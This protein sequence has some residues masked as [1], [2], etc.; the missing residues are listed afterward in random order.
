MSSEGGGLWQIIQFN[1][2]AVE[3]EAR[4]GTPHTHDQPFVLLHDVQDIFPGAARFQCGKRAVGFMVDVDGNKLQPLRVPYLPGTPLEVIVS[5][6]QTTTPPL[7]PSPSPLARERASRI[8]SQKLRPRLLRSQPSGQKQELAETPV[9]EQRQQGSKEELRDEDGLPELSLDQQL[10]LQLQQPK[11]DLME[12]RELRRQQRQQRQQGTEQQAQLDEQMLRQKL[13][14]LEQQ[15]IQQEQERLRQQKLRRQEQLRQKQQQQQEQMHQAQP[16]QQE[17]A[18]E[19]QEQEQQEQEQQEQ[20]QQEQEHQEEEQQE[21]QQGQKQEQQEQ[22]QEQ[23]QREQQ[24]EQRQQRLSRQ[25]RQQQQQQQG[26]SERAAT[27]P[28]IPAPTPRKPRLP[29]IP[30]DDPNSNVRIST[31]SAKNK[32]RKSV[33]LY[34]SFLHHIRAGQTEQANVVK[35]DFRHHFNNLEL[36]MAKNQD[37]QERMLEMQQTMLE[38]QQRSL[39][40]LAVIQNRVQAILVQ[41][42]ELHEYP[43]PR[44]FVVLPK[45]S[46]RWDS[47]NLFQNKF[48]LYF[49]CECG[50]HTKSSQSKIP[51]HIHLAKHEGYDIER[52]REFFRRYG[53]YVLKLLQMLKYGVAVG[54]FA[55][56]ALVPSRV[57]ESVRRNNTYSVDGYSFDIEP[58]VNQAIEFLQ[59]L[60]TDGEVTPNGIRHPDDMMESL[61]GSDLRRLGAFLK[62]K[63]EDHVLGNLYRV[64]TNQGHV[65][66][67]CLDHYRETYNTLAMRELEDIATVNGGLVDEHYG[68]VVI[69]LYSSA[70]ATQFYRALERAKFVQELK[71]KLR[72]DITYSDAKAF[73]E[74][75]NRSNISALELTCTASN[76]AGELLNRNKRAE[77]LW[78]ILSNPKIRSFSLDG[79][80]GFFRRASLEV[81]PSE[82]RVLRIS[83]EIDWKKDY[84]KVVE[85]LQMS[86]H[87][88]DLTLG[89]TNMNEAYKAIR[90]AASKRCPLS[91]LT[92]KAG[93][94]ERLTA[95][96]EQDQAL[97]S[98]D[99]VIPNLTAYS[100]LLKAADCIS[101]LHISSQ[102]NSY[103]DCAP[104]VD[105]INRNRNLTELKIACYVSEFGLVYE[106]IR[107]SVV[108]NRSSRLKKVCIYRAENQLT[109]TDIRTPHLLSLELLQMN[110]HDG[111]LAQLL[112]T[113]GSKL[114]KL[115]I[116]TD[117]WRPIHSAILREAFMSSTTG[118]RLTHLYQTIAGVDEGILRELSMVIN[119]SNLAEYHMVIDQ[120]F[121]IDPER[122]MYWV[123]YI[124]CIG[125]KL[126]SLV[127]ACP[128]PNE[129]VAALG[130]ADFPAMERISFHHP[131]QR[132]QRGGLEYMTQEHHQQQQ[133]SKSE[134]DAN[135]MRRT[136]SAPEIHGYPTR[137]SA[138]TAN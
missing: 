61:E 18:Q 21:H 35:E 7:R 54:G 115:R 70:V 4:V 127:V 58:S 57:G 69:A 126:S 84:A 78:Q 15:Q 132:I 40:R 45:D 2:Q 80:S 9:Q 92:L 13:V 29:S 100:H 130:N 85:M 105:V 120:A 25:Q 66:W 67:V 49:L 124:T 123:D 119:R 98:M 99:L 55:V 22:Q 114:T 72:W 93:P 53:H 37:L 20:E 90:E 122:A 136:V 103:G 64:V 52:P 106:A 8:S 44:L 113:F 24:R 17:Q 6:V 74:T 91:K 96:F 39:D 68:R 111:V 1:G 59:A 89:C 131:G 30:P 137:D 50:D 109:T 32:Y 47:D 38:M 43:V 94:D 77:P 128:E 82:V 73:K 118:S 33:M 63:D 112:S 121:K 60:L 116:D 14:G 23:Q 71:V 108:A 88:T 86:P 11:Q 19:Q 10:E 102:T 65:K 138:I 26:R 51:H 125:E 31:D 42:Y 134:V 97:V 5:D 87:L 101:T 79:Y 75:I 3:V 81:R 104:I 16:Q 12:Q 107:A 28:V 48:R 135:Y 41:N 133:Y 83:D 56:P 62:N 76:S 110:I 46:T 117:R 36:E 129:W 27:P 95:Q 34:Q